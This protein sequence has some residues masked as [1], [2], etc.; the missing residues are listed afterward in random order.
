MDGTGWTILIITLLTMLSLFFSLH[1]IAMRSIPKVV[2]YEAF[3]KAGKEEK[4][5]SY[6]QQSESM[7]LTCGFMRLVCNSGILLALAALMSD[8]HYLITLLT[9]V[10]IIEV[11]S[12]AIPHSWA[13]HAGQYFLP[14][15]FPLMG[16]IYLLFKPM[17]KLFEWH[18]RL[19]RRIVGLPAST[20]DAVK[21][22]QLLDLVE[23]SK[24][25]GVVDEEEVNMIENVL[26]L[27]EMTAEEIMTPRTDI[28]ALPVTANLPAVIKI[29]NDTGHSR[30]PVYEST[31]DN[32]IGI[33]YVKDLLN[34][35]NEDRPAFDM[36]QKM[37]SAYF[38]PETKPLRN[39]L[40]EFKKQKLHIAVV[41]DEYGGTAGIVT[42]EDIFEHLVGD[43]A[44]EYEKP[45][46]EAFQKISE[47]LAEADARIYID[48]INNEFDIELPDEED[49]DTLGGFV[50]SH[51]GY[52]PK[53]GQTFDY[54]NLRFTVVAAEARSVRRVRI[55]KLLTDEQDKS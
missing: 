39:L 29:L 11:F 52:I 4:S 32:I 6:F 55:E 7:Y 30:L 34:D 33:L 42:I 23:Q 21:E 41:L 45:E 14:R 13:K 16:V 25:E 22:E 38:V 18:D 10:I 15:T 5:E 28:V 1:S 43:I 53:T 2:L 46:P 19:V 35:V 37:R 20:S 49:Y 47:N 24:L 44:D 12:L 51:L 9:A 8:R 27:D 3:R 40:H 50:F 36:Q 26:E 54:T 31:V 17:L 48:D